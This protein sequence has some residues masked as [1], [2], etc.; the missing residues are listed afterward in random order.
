MYRQNLR[1]RILSLILSIASLLTVCVLPGM[2]I[3][4]AAAGDPALCADGHLPV[5]N[6]AGDI[7][8]TC[9]QTGIKSF[10][11]SRCG[12][13]CDVTVKPLFHDF[14]DEWIT[15]TEPTCTQTGIARRHCT[16]CEAVTGEKIIPALG[17]RVGDWETELPATCTEHGTDICYCR[18]CD[19]STQR[20]TPLAEHTDEDGDHYCDECGVRFGI[21]I[22]GSTVIHNQDNTFEYFICLFVQ[23]FTELK[24][25]FGIA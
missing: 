5:R 23:I 8:P 1:R 24:N 13:N 9:T 4:S 12:E 18:F 17:H 2:S 19:Y 21:C 22:C 16:R 6:E 3:S 20:T 14:A 7:A 10:I 15:E 25:T 11:C